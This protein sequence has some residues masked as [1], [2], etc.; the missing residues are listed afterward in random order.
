MNSNLNSNFF[1]SPKTKNNIFKSWLKKSFKNNYEV[2]QIIIMTTTEEKLK[3]ELGMKKD[4]ATRATDKE[5]QFNET[6]QVRTFTR[7][8]SEI[9]YQRFGFKIWRYFRILDAII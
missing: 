6:I 2:Q 7:Q 8:P 3:G 1:L 5:V 4:A 9:L